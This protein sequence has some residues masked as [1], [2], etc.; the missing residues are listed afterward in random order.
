MHSAWVIRG[1]FDGRT[2]VPD[3]PLPPL[4]GTAELIVF[5]DATGPTQAPRG[6]IFDLIGKA[7]QLR[8]GEDIAAQIREERESWG[9]P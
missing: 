2:F 8:T 6:S 7:P 1:H 5:P 9:E 3:E 4:K